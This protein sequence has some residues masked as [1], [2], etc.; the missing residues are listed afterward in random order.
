[1]WS[2]STLHN[3]DVIW[4]CFSW[5]PLKK[6]LQL[7]KQPIAICLFCLFDFGGQRLSTK[8]H[9][10][11][12]FRILSC[13]TRQTWDVIRQTRVF[14]TKGMWEQPWWLWISEAVGGVGVI[15]LGAAQSLEASGDSGGPGAEWEGGF[16]SRGE[17][18]NSTPASVF[19]PVLIT[20]SD[21]SHKAGAPP[22]E[23]RRTASQCRSEPLCPWQHERKLLSC[24]P[25][26]SFSPPA[27]WLCF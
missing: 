15:V 16:D 12:G 2:F 20:L 26:E 1:M 13:D 24:L 18:W 14:M 11:A 9:W 3:R 27:S 8:W 23:N 6:Q 21:D 10:V 25:A 4:L 19:I 5:R 22:P 7:Q 17:R